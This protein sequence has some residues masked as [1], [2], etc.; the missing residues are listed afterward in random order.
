MQHRRAVLQKGGET[1]LCP[2]SRSWEATERGRGQEKRATEALLLES[3]KLNTGDSSVDVKRRGDV[4]RGKRLTKARCCRGE[5]EG[6]EESEHGNTVYTGRPPHGEGPEPAERLEQRYPA[7]A[8]AVHGAIRVGGRNAQ[9]G[10]RVLGPGEGPQVLS[11]VRRKAHAG[12]STEG[13]RKRAWC[14]APCPYPTPSLPL[15]G[16]AEAQR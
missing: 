16:A 1:P 15:P 10:F 8:Q 2:L 11:P 9:A 14:N 4:V 7:H 6:A 3:Y 12:F 13:M 5:S